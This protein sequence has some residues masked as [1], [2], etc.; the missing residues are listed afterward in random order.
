MTLKKKAIKDCSMWSVFYQKQAKHQMI[1]H[2]VPGISCEVN[3][4]DIFQMKEKYCLCIV[5]YFRKFL[6][7]WTAYKKNVSHLA[8]NLSLPNTGYNKNI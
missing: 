4:A 6:T 8:V 1:Q 7:M 5:D 2:K 3:G